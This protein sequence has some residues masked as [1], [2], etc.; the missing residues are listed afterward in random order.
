MIAKTDI[1][2]ILIIQTASIGDVVLATPVVEKLKDFYPDAKIDFL[3]KNGIHSLLTSHPKIKRVLVW[4][5]SVDKYKHL[6]QLIEVIRERKYDVV[7]NLQRF[8][9]SG[10][11]TALSG[12]PIRLGFNKNPFSIFFTKSVK[13]K[14]SAD[15]GKSEH[16]VSRNLS[17]IDSITDTSRNYPLKLYPT[18]TDFAKVSQYKTKKYICLAPTSL[19]F[20]K[21][22]PA[23]KWI[24]FLKEI[25]EDL[26]VYFLGAKSDSTICEQIIKESGH[27][28]S[29]NLAGKLSFLESA[30][31]MKD[32]AM[33]F[34]N[35]SAPQ[36][37]ASA[38][39]APLTTIFCSTVPAFGFG[40]LSND[41]VVIE[42][43]EILSCRP[44][45]LHGFNACPEKHY[46]CALS[47]KKEKLLDRII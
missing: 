44:C 5:K 13:H 26:V 45:G 43:D 24:E 27:R 10:L 33:N 29:L 28:N 21:Q 38:V 18:L 40:P 35:D 37:F 23:E 7:V 31:L 9:A 34:V 17:V 25:A 8:A 2:R 14:I 36:H 11:I 47:I 32:A 22:Y 42:T 16:E 19:W 30:A 20:T 46:K 41:A 3:V 39:N 6:K 4:D 12:A 15:Q 1:K